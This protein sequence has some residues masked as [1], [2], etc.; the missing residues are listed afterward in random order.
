MSDA[1]DAIR[2]GIANLLGLRVESVPDPDVFS[3]EQDLTRMG[4]YVAPIG[5]AA[6]HPTA[7]TTDPRTSDG[8]RTYSLKAGTQ[9]AKLLATFGRWP[10]DGLTDEQA[11]ERTEG[12][13]PFSE[14]ATRCSELRN[15]GW[16]TD[17]GK[18]R[19]GNSGTP[20]IVSRITEAGKAELRR[21][22]L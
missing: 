19:K 15:A 17:T 3:F 13:G 20:R 10:D 8:T 1:K 12:V 21:L 22:G 5:R 11:M 18:D 2:K 7:R 16:I 6:D 14:Y 4:Y 9:R